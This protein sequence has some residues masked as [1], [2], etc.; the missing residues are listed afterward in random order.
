MNRRTFLRGV[1]MVGMGGISGEAAQ[2]WGQM[3]AVARPKATAGQ[4]HNL[5]GLSEVDTYN[6]QRD[7]AVIGTGDPLD[8]LY[9]GDSPASRPIVLLGG[10]MVVNGCGPTSSELLGPNGGLLRTFASYIPAGPYLIMANVR[11]MGNLPHRFTCTVSGWQQAWEMSG[12]PGDTAS[13]NPPGAINLDIFGNSLTDPA[14]WPLDLSSIAATTTTSFMAKVNVPTGL[15]Q[16]VLWVQWYTTGTQA[17][18]LGNIV[19]NRL[20]D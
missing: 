17:W 18:E 4:A 12:P 8:P 9:S 2:V 1:A 14:D 3:N 7:N 16:V 15:F 13:T 20:A 11:N 6:E 19:M 10:P 5:G